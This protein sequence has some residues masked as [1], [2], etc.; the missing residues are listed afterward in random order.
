M[1]NYSL[2]HQLQ[3]LGIVMTCSSFMRF[4]LKPPTSPQVSRIKSTFQWHDVK[5]FWLSHQV[6]LRHTG[7]ISRGIY[8]VQS[9]SFLCVKCNYISEWP[10]AKWST[11]TVNGSKVNGFC[12]YCYHDQLTTT[13]PALVTYHFLNYPRPEKPTFPHSDFSSI[14][15]TTGSPYA[16]TFLLTLFTED[17]KGREKPGS[18][19]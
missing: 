10:T 6:L 19:M 2:R 16:D 9:F 8:A 3:L 17:D 13:F 11:L 5:K 18:N 7:T 15:M 12:G 4:L 1:L 14:S